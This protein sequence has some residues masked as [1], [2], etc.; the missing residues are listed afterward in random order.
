[1]AGH[2]FGRESRRLLIALFAVA[3]GCR[4]T[5]KSRMSTAHSMASRDSAALAAYDDSVLATLRVGGPSAITANGDTLTT[6]GGG[7]MDVDGL[8][9]FGSEHYARNGIQFVRITQT[10]GRQ[11]D[12]NPVWAVRARLRLPPMD[13]T[14]AL[15]LNGLCGNNGKLDP[16]IL[17]ITGSAV[18]SVWFQATHAWRFEL[19]GQMLHEI[20]ATGVTC[21][22]LSG[23]D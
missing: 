14:Q 22:H 5:D 1:L 23:E 15:A 17:A 13:S 4:N 2:S 8:R 11:P 3:A 21:A 16:L 20:P 19:P 9:D 18:D 10:V 6:F 12:G 7:L